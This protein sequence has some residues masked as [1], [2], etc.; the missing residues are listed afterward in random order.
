[1]KTRLI[2]LWLTRALVLPLAALGAAYCLKPASAQKPAPMPLVNTSEATAQFLKLFDTLDED[3]DGIVPLPVIF[4]ALNLL[5]AEARQVKRARALD[6]NGDGKVTRAEANA[7]IHAEIVYQTKRGM[8]TDADGDEA[9][10]PQEYALSY[11]DPN[12]KADANGLT[13]AQLRGFKDDDLN[14]DGKVTRDEIETRVVQAY[15]G[16]YWMQWMAVRA[17][18]ADR[19]RDGVIDETEFA[20][21]EGTAALSPEAQKRFQTAGAKDGKLPIQN[22]QALFF[23]LAGETQRTA[24]EK[25]MDDF[26]R[27]LKAVAQPTPG[28][29]Q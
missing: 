8:N 20:A 22:T 28:E 29:K 19:N 12:G 5:Q 10:T 15:A 9:L 17:R 24:K 18:R 6:G 14:G 16:G 21:L 26:E 23:R 4:E 3:R 2:V 7:G 11:A 27:G 25:Q 13:P 1:M